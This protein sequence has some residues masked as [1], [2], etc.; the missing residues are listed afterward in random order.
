MVRSQTEYWYQ[1]SK[2]TSRAEDKGGEAGTPGEPNNQGGWKTPKGIREEK[3]AYDKSDKLTGKSKEGYEKALD[4]LSRGE[5]GSNVHKL[6]GKLAGKKAVDLPGS[7]KGR[8]KL[9]IIYS[10][11]EN[12]IVVH[13][14]DN[15]H[16]NK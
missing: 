1:K 16:R 4:R 7:G 15:Y 10:E 5:S 3:A 12:G 2:G 9:R 11:T 6:T 13:D 14:I 8:G